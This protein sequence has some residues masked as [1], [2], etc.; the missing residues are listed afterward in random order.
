[1]PLSEPGRIGPRTDH[2]KVQQPNGMSPPSPSPALALQQLIDTHDKETTPEKTN[3][4]FSV[5]EI[6][7]LS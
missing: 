7:P 6:P 2:P 5:S 1:M 4:T 3:N